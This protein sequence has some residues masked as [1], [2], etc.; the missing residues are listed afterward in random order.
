VTESAAIKMLPPAMTAPL[1]VTLPDAEIDSTWLERTTPLLASTV[2]AF[3]SSVPT[4]TLASTN[5]IVRAT[6]SLQFGTEQRT[7]DTT[8]VC[9][10][11]CTNSRRASTTPPSVHVEFTQTGDSACDTTT[12]SNQNPII[13]AVNSASL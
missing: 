9:S 13:I 1:T 8:S 12:K 5:T 6:C 4:V 10:G 3:A 7:P 11:S 2:V